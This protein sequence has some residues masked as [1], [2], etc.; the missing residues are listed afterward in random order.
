MVDSLYYTG[1]K[2]DIGNDNYFLYMCEGQRGRGKTTFWLQRFVNRYFETGSRFIYLRRSE[3][4]MEL[5]LEKG[6][7]NCCKGVPEY[8]EFWYKYPKTETRNGNIYL[9]DT[10]NDKHLVG[11]YITLNNVKGIS[12]E[13]ADTLLFDEYVA[14]SRSKY[15]GGDSGL[16]EP[17]LFLRLADTLFR[18]RKFWCV[19]LGNRD[20]PSNP[21]NECWKVPFNINLYKNKARGVWYEYDFSEATAERKAKTVL[22]I[23]SSGTSYSDYSMG[24]KSLDEVDESLIDIKPTHATQVYNVKIFG[25]LMTMWS[26]KLNGVLYAT[27]DCKYNASCGTICVSNSD[28]T[29]NT[30]FI[31][32]DGVFVEVMKNFYGQGKMRFNNQET[33]SLFLTML[34][35][36]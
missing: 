18:Y 5:A 1:S 7:F 21:Y 17:E 16:H 34:S 15:K 33:A 9:I 2:F 19:L 25:K 6:L 4:E 14:I 31:K 20:T 27:T 30:D 8:R 24:L 12:I 10:N 22:G 11:Y 3:V 36:N 29:I 35:L 26:D 32:Y 13:D 28:M 23:I